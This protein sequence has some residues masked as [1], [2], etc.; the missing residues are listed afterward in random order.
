LNAGEAIMSYAERYVAFV[1]ILG[2]KEII[3]QSEHGGRMF[4]A[5]VKSLTSMGDRNKDLE[6]VLGEDFKVQNF[7]DAVVLSEKVTARGLSH[8]LYE[9]QELAL[10][11]LPSGLLIRGG[12]SKGSLYHEGSVVFGPAFLEAYRL[13]SSVASVPRIVLTREV[14]SDVVQYSNDDDRWK[15]DFDSDLRYSE[16]GPVHVHVLKR[17]QSLNLHEP[18]IEFLNSD[19]V[20]HAQ[21]CQ[22]ALQ[23]LIDQSMHEPR[24]FDK[25]KWFAIYWNGTV[26]R[27]ANAPLK[28][29]AFPY[30]S[31]P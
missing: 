1:D 23:S 6:S 9:I 14:Y 31:R 3:R 13:E 15:L 20:I 27:G 19:E 18:T 2:F 25:V 17:F 24:H 16:D 8:L 7:S 21:F 12:I 5:L 30:M 22:S 4:E 28:T 11:L 26:P 29:V 10:S